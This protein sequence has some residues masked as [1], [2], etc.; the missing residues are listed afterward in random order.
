MLCSKSDLHS[1]TKFP[2]VLDNLMLS[3]LGIPLA[4]PPP[5]FA[6]MLGN[7]IATPAEMH[8]FLLLDMDSV[9][10]FAPVPLF[11]LTDQPENFFLVLICQGYF[12]LIS[13]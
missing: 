6:L 12:C 10:E 7:D 5:S 3:L 13:L 8:R 2:Y 4:P 9:S 1:K 11:K